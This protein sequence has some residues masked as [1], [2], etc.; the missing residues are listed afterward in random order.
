MWSLYNI[1][2]HNS[3]LQPRTLFITFKKQKPFW[4][5]QTKEQTSSKADKVTLKLTINTAHNIPD[6]EIG[7]QISS[8]PSMAGNTTSSK[9]GRQ[10]YILQAGMAT[11]HPPSSDGNTTSSKLGWQHYTE[12][13]SL[14][15]PYPA[16]ISLTLSLL[17]SPPPHAHT[18]YLSWP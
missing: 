4:R 14:W 10:H 13:G 7:K 1:K 16:F 8:P 17:L 15:L 18:S 11:L 6:A 12:A 2:A 5:K 3:L 9:H